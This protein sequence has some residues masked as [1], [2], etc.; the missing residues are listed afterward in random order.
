MEVLLETDRL[1]VRRFTSDEHGRG[2]YAIDRA[3]WEHDRRPA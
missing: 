3:Q 1:L 2:E